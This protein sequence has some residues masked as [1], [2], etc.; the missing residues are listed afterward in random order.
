MY[1]ARSRRQNQSC[2]GE[3]ALAA[4]AASC[5][6]AG[7]SGTTLDVHLRTCDTKAPLTGVYVHVREMLSVV[8]VGPVSSGTTNSAGVAR[9]SVPEAKRPYQGFF[10]WNG[11]TYRFLFDAGGNAMRLDRDQETNQVPCV[12]VLVTPVPLAPEPFQPE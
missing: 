2:K 4:I 5:V 9:V 7:C 1:A 11:A 12:D 8:S 6:L 10:E 3:L